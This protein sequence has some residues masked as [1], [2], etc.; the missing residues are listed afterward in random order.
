[1]D[2]RHKFEEADISDVIQA[3][4]MDIGRRYPICNARRVET[5]YGPSV[6]LTIDGFRERP[7]SLFLPKR[8][9]AVFSDDDIC[10]IHSKR[11]LFH[12]VYNGTDDQSKAYIMSIV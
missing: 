5:R 12:I 2:L 1:M 8:Y 7:V 11:S 10:R 3:S 9:S 6:L 4:E